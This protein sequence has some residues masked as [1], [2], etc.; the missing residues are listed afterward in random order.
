MRRCAQIA[1]RPENHILS[2]V[3]RPNIKLPMRPVSTE[4]FTPGDCAQIVQQL[5]QAHLK[6]MV[7]DERRLH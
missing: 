6:Q 5:G 2:L 1:K 3:R 4:G 7:T